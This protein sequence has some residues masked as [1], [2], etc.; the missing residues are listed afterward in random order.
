ML[1][2]IEIENFKAFGKRQ[3]IEI[4]PITLIFGANSA[5]KTSLFHALFYLHQLF[6]DHRSNPQELSHFADHIDLG[7]FRQAVFDHDIEQTIKLKLE[8]DIQEEDMSGFNVPTY[9]V[10]LSGEEKGHTFHFGASDLTV[11]VH[12]AAF[13]DGRACYAQQ[14]RLDLD[15]RNAISLVAKNQDSRGF[16]NVDVTFDYDVLDT[17]GHPLP[18]DLSDVVWPIFYGYQC[19]PHIG[20][21]PLSSGRTDMRLLSEQD[22]QF[23]NEMDV[24][25][26]TAVEMVRQSLEDCLYIGPTRDVPPPEYSPQVL[27]AVKRWSKGLAAWDYLH[28]AAYMDLQN[29]NHWLGPGGVNSG[30]QIDQQHM[31]PVSFADSQNRSLQIQSTPRIRLATYDLRN[32]AKLSPRSLR[33]Q[34]VGFGISQ[35]VPVITALTIAKQNRVLIEQPELHLHPRFQTELGDLLISCCRPNDELDDEEKSIKT[36]IIETH[37][38]HLILRILRRIR[39]TSEGDLP[40]G[41]PSMTPSDLAVYYFEQTDEGTKATHLRVDEEGEFVDRWP[42]GFFDERAEELF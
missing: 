6:A 34:D 26:L 28:L 1:T 27:P 30:I 39:E 41:A 36:A 5:G 23:A 13:G 12:V 29:V 10:S 9:R 8:F 35:V 17:F 33:I 7:G 14:L 19:I 20:D 24:I 42:Y 3:R 31:V 4:K 16:W 22:R 32:P 11:E 21:P 38:E 37:S 2:A 15:G 18:E 40:D 25:L